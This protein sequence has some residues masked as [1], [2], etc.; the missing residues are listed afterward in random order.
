MGTMVAVPSIFHGKD[1]FRPQNSAIE[2]LGSKW[3]K[4]D[5]QSGAEIDE[6]NTLVNLFGN[7]AV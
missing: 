2:G 7:D 6:I 5:L 1:Q 4:F 3:I